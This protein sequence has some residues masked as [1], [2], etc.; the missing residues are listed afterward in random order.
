MEDYVVK[1]NLLKKLIMVSL[2]VV[3]TAAPLCAMEG[4]AAAAAVEAAAAGA[5]QAGAVVQRR[6]AGADAQERETCSICLQEV[7][8]AL[9][10]QTGCP[11]TT[12]ETRVHEFCKECL[13][14]WIKTSGQFPAICPTCRHQLSPEALRKIFGDGLWQ[15]MQQKYHQLRPAARI[16]LNC[17]LGAAAYIVF[18]I[19]LMKF[20]VLKPDA[21][22][23]VGIGLFICLC[24]IAQRVYFGVH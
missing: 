2:A 6:G 22:S 5:A 15:R 10:I 8:K 3:A 19:A 1:K 11:R 4:A 24:W 18:K 16:L 20:H 23:F 12:A 14:G 7:A 9:L 21:D 17:W 13:T